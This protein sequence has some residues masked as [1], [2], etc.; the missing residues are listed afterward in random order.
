MAIPEWYDEAKFKRY[1]A[2][3]FYKRNAYVVTLS[4][5]YGLIAV[6]AV[7]SVLNVLM[8]TKKSSTPFTAYR[9]Y[10]LTILHFTIWYRD[11]LAP[12]TRFWRSLLYTR[13]A[14][15]GT[16]K[17][18]SAAKEGMIISQRDMVLVQFSFAGYVVLKPE[19][20][21][22]QGS[23]QEMDD[24]IHFWRVV[25]FMLGIHDEY[26][27]CTTDSTTSKRRMQLV[28]DQMMGPALTSPNEDFYRMTKA[29]LD[30]MW[31]YNVTLDYEALLFIT[32][33]L[34]GVAGYGF[35]EH[36]RKNQLKVTGPVTYEKLSWYSRF[37]VGRLVHMHEEGL[38]NCLVR[39]L[40][41]LQLQFSVLVGICYLP[42]LAAIK[43]G[44]KNA[45]V[46]MPK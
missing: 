4:V 11:P 18:T 9:R 39:W 40:M 15:D 46:K 28:L 16:I 17:R 10:L 7:P 20:L 30:G 21:G 14:H 1:A 32:F 29:L 35:L 43:F 31:Y 19:M 38:K 23:A 12:G 13:K 3:A 27:L 24:F 8:F 36:E 26:N 33:R 44:W 6:M 42:L 34:N 22:I 41:N 2:Q 25:G 45:V 37:I 5:L